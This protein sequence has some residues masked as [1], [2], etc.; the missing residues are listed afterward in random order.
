MV[1]WEYCAK[2]LDVSDTDA[3]S[4]ALSSMSENGW[5]LV[6]FSYEGSFRAGYQLFVFKKAQSD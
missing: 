2:A 4:N 5:E 6:N 1:K 3:L